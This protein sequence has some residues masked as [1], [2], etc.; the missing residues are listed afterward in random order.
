MNSAKI[1]FNSSMYNMENYEVNISSEEET[2]NLFPIVL[3]IQ[4][5]EVLCELIIKVKHS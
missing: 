3:E 2:D 5:N 4:T 1:N